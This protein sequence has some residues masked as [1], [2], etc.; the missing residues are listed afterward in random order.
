MV[1]LASLMR[2][3]AGLGG[4]QRALGA[5]EI[6]EVEVRENEELL[7]AKDIFLGIDLEAPGLVAHVNEHGFAHVAVRGDAPGHG[8]FAAFHVML[9]SLFAGFR[10]GEFVLERKNA[11]GLQRFE[12]GLALFNE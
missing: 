8:H 9:A 7:V 12:L 10:G 11:F 3:F 6:A 2:D 4:E 5:D 1:K